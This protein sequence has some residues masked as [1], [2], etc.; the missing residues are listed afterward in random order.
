MTNANNE[1]LNAGNGFPPNSIVLRGNIACRQ[2]EPRCP[3]A[4]GIC[5][6]SFLGCA[7]LRRPKAVLCN[8]FRVNRME[9][10]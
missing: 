4:F 1:V 5:S 7:A 9:E 2:T 10:H 3:L 6:V 8:P